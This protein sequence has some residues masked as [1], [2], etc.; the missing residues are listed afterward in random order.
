MLQGSVDAWR[1]RIPHRPRGR[2][3]ARPGGSTARVNSRRSFLAAATAVLLAAPFT[4]EAQQAGKV[5]RLG[6]PTADPTVTTP[7][8][9]EAFREG[10]RG[11]GS[12]GGERRL[13]ADP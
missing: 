12:G 8:L 7:R 13:R 10:L 6:W 4:T 9:N 11:L 5:W 1:E 2:E 3:G